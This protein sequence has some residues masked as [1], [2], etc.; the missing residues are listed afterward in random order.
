MLKSY[1]ASRGVR[2]GTWRRLLHRLCSRGRYHRWSLSTL[3][4]NRQ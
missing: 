3:Y 2:A 4:I 1:V